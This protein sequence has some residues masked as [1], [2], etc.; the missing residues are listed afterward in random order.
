MLARALAACL[1][2]WLVGWM[3]GVGVTRPGVR[4]PKRIAVAKHVGE[5]LDDVNAILN[6]QYHSSG[7]SAAAAGH[8]GSATHHHSSDRSTLDRLEGD[9]LGRWLLRHLSRHSQ[10]AGHY[11][12][13][14]AQA[15]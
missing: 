13:R 8:S 1:L 4:S 6:S 14:P 10:I 15:I 12:C 11:Y 9:T 3:A 7:D 2:G 5:S